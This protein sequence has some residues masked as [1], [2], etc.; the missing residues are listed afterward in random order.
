MPK[1]PT[2]HRRATAIATSRRSRQELDR[3]RAIAR[4]GTMDS[5][6]ALDVLTVTIRDV[7]VGGSG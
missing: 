4:A 6:H 5:K 2:D 3:N 7:F 1:A